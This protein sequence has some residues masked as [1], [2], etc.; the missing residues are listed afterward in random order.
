MK[1]K[2]QVE[3]FKKKSVEH[4]QKRESIEGIFPKD[5][6]YSGIKNEVNEIK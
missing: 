1:I 2:E 4:Q 6:E 5:L 3:A